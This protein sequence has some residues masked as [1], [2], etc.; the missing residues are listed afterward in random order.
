MVDLTRDHVS[1][2]LDAYERAWRSPGTADLDGLFSEH[3][4]YRMAPYEDAVSG[5]DAVRRLWDEERDGPEE[6]F[7]LTS[8]IVAVDGPVAVVLAEVAYAE[9]PRD[10]R[11]LWV[12]RFAAD[13]RCESYEEW[14]Y[15]PGQPLS[16][17]AVGPAQES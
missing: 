15:W 8:E 7:E 4:S 10:Y 5:I 16:S 14:P 6:P 3:A 1:W 12:L 2:W 13:G 9:P 11:D 17:R